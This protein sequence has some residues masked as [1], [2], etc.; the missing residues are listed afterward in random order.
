MPEPSSWTRWLGGFAVAASLAAL[1]GPAAGQA[2]DQVEDGNTARTDALFGTP[3]I[4]TPVPDDTLF[5]TTPGLERQLRRSQFTISGLVPM[6]YNSN[7]DA[8]PYAGTNSGEFSPVLGIAWS[9]PVFDLPFR[10]TANGRAEVDRFT[11]VPTADFDKLAVSGRLQYVDASN[12]QAYSPYVSYA[13]RWDFMPFYRNWRATRQDVNVG[14]NKVF[15]FDA[16]FNRVAPSG[17]TFAA[18]AWSFGVTAALQR[19][20][21]DPTPGSWAAFL[22]P[23]ATYVF[24]SSWNISAGVLLERRAFDAVGGVAQEDWLVEPIVTL[25][26]VAPAS[27]FGSTAAA[28]A[29]GRPA[30][31]FQVAYEK[32]WSNVAGASFEVLHVGAALKLG[33]RF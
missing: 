23:S 5:A 24:S 33:W 3:N 22:V 14:V 4:V 11:Q 25:E 27:W 18:T 30:L 7:A 26:F 16:D 19:R 8:L 10:F 17:D 32:N 15:N 20:F 21:R 29:V 1:A 12:D 31:D 6:F 9:T 2:R 28:T 13:P